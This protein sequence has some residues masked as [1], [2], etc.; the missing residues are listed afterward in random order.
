MVAPVSPLIQLKELYRASQEGLRERL[1]EEKARRQR[2]DKLR[3]FTDEYNQ[4]ARALEEMRLNRKAK[5]HI[6]HILT[7]AR[8]AAKIGETKAW[9]PIMDSHGDSID[10][11]YESPEVLPRI[12]KKLADMN[13]EVDTM[14]HR[15]SDAHNPNPGCCIKIVVSGWADN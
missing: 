13:L 1:A 14:F 5:A 12:L 3:S 15:Y 10:I 7:N 2:E 4:R 8:E 6:A 9:V 11:A